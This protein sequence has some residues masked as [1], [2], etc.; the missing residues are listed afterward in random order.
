MTEAIDTPLTEDDE[1]GVR[2]NV[3]QS[4]ALEAERR[5]ESQNIPTPDPGDDEVRRQPHLPPPTHTED[6]E[7]VI[8]YWDLRELSRPDRRARLIIAKLTA[9]WLAELR[10]PVPKTWYLYGELIHVLINL[11]LLW[12]DS[13]SPAE[14]D[15]FWQNVWTHVHS[16]NWREALK[17]GQLVNPKDNRIM[18]LDF[19][20]TDRHPEPTFEMLLDRL[21]EEDI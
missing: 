8:R 3:E 2:Y 1:E 7:E 18:G 5:S 12:Q 4:D 10:I 21:T 11:D 19:E 13:R 20:T 15:R 9:L 17:S 14:I 16:D 6:D